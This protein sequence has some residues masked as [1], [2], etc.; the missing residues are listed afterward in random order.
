MTFFSE[1]LVALVLNMLSKDTIIWLRRLA[2]A[3]AI[4]FIMYGLVTGNV[5][6]G[7]MGFLVIVLI[8]LPR[9]FLY[10]DL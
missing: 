9:L 7:L 8:V 6:A 1:M 5:V 10:P 3:G 4:G 2:L